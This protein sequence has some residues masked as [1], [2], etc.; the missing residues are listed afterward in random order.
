MSDSNSI[1]GLNKEQLSRLFPF[2]VAFDRDMRIVHHGHVA[3]KVCRNICVGVTFS[4]IFT[5]FRP[6]LVSTFD[7]IVRQSNALF[8]LD[9]VTTGIRMRGQIVLTA[10]QDIALFLGTPWFTDL[11]QLERTGLELKD[12]T[13]HD[14]IVDFIYMV[15][16]KTLALEDA[17]LLGDKIKNQ[18]DELEVKNRELAHASTAKS[19]FL[20]NTSHELRTPLN[21]VIGMVSL[22]ARTELDPVQRNYTETVLRSANAL[23]TVV[24]D[25][26]DFSKM[27]AGKLTLVD[28]EVELDQLIHEVAE[29]FAVTTQTKSIEL[30]CVIDAMVPRIVRADAGRLRQIL[31]NLLG[32]AVKFTERGEVIL[33]VEA[34]AMVSDRTVIRFSITDT[35]IGIEPDKLEKLFVAFSQVDGSMSRRF[36]GTGLGLAIS[37]QIIELMGGSI[38][39]ESKIGEGSTFWCTASFV[40]VLHAAAPN[41]HLAHAD[42]QNMRVLVIDDNASSREMLSSHLTRWGVRSDSARD[43]LEGLASLRDAAAAG[44]PY[45][46][47]VVDLQM[48]RMSGLDLAMILAGDPTFESLR[49]IVLTSVDRGL[50]GKTRDA[51]VRIDAYLTKPVRASHLFNLLVS[52]AAQR[53]RRRVSSRL[54]PAPSS[55]PHKIDAVTMYSSS[56]ILIVDDHPVNQE[57]ALHMLSALGY[58]ADRASNGRE[59]LEALSRRRYS[60]VLMDLQMPEMDGHQATIEIRRRERGGER[61][62]VVAMTAHAMAGDQQNALNNGM[63]GY[64]PKPLQFESLEEVLRQWIPSAEHTESSRRSKAPTPIGYGD[65]V[66]P[67][68][69]NQLRRYQK[70]GGPDLVAPVIRSFLADLPR[71]VDAVNAAR[72]GRWEAVVDAAHALRASSATVGALRLPHLCAELESR[73]RSGGHDAG[74]LLKRFEY[75]CDQVRK[76]LEALLVQPTTMEKSS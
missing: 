9:S 74:E 2:L 54:P 5:T 1:I 68:V 19:Q 61:T 64:L 72:A 34:V 6:R 31:G 71:R 46:V 50:E 49:T 73:G 4:E 15:Q 25:V 75:E 57:V 63:D 10:N 13:D 22:L 17:K 39:A 27:E 70:K 20:A 52:V 37:K 65:S 44:R 28:E 43:A 60:L 14:P 33:R 30:I 67:S 32:N 59:A 35:G 42:L 24:N 51:R 38:G 3:P 7:T 58:E 66:D 40:N 36:G 48:P 11:A 23:L 26:L 55:P 45:E 21:G 29:L 16:A 12:F 76:G 41:S 47:A 56:R 53:T 18:R 69:L 62:P 8:L